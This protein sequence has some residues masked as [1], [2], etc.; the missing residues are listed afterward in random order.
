[1]AWYEHFRGNSPTGE[2]QL[3][4]GTALRL[5]NL[6]VGLVPVIFGW[7]AIFAVAE[8][9]HSDPKFWWYVGGVLALSLAAELVL[10]YIGQMLCYK[11]GYTVVVAFRR[12]IA[13]HL[14][15]LPLGFFAKNRMGEINAVLTDDVK[16]AEDY[17]THFFVELVLS[18]A[19][20]LV[21]LAVI[22]AIDYRLALSLVVLLPLGALILARFARV[23][24]RLVGEQLER[25]R[26][27]SAR[28][29]EYAFGIKTLRVFHRYDV[30]AEPLRKRLAAIRA[31]SMPIESAGGIGVLSFRLLAELGLALM[32]WLAAE[33]YSDSASP[34]AAWVLVLLL[35][36][37]YAFGILEASEFYASG[38]MVEKSGQNLAAVLEHPVFSTSTGGE[39]PAAITRSAD[40]LEVKGVSFSYT[41]GQNALTDV[42]LA[43]PEGTITAIVGPSGSGKSTLLSLLSGFYQPSE[44]RVLL[45]GKDYA[46]LGAD[47]I[48]EQLGVVFQDSFIFDGT[49]AA[50]VKLGRPEAS[51]DEVVAACEAALCAEFIAGLPEGYETML[52]EDGS[53]LSG[54]ERQRLAIARMMIKNPAIIIVDEMT[55]QL[56]PI[57]QFQVQ[58]ALSH[59]AR[60]K[61][62]IMVAHRLHTTKAADQIAVMD[63][64]R[65]VQL[66]RHDELLAVDD[67]YRRLWQSQT[68]AD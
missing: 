1:M 26:D 58:N 38:R 27:L 36:F 10:S 47:Q 28:L 15:N 20:C 37:R 61:T 48:Y 19:L 8:N 55:A 7:W 2:R 42:S 64:G 63:K 6:I 54:G 41:A 65:I 57:N 34:V 56:D 30:L 60:G 45:A 49:V 23:F 52:G 18:V 4:Q 66:G 5:L 53:R 68:G 11:G 22:I 9:R 29:V 21:I 67:L 43:I 35:A 39:P 3:V 31:A 12:R 32:F 33:L 46:A 40:L 44:G 16:K 51:H 50:N 24:A 13:D 14:R 17:F 59:L 25:Y 62:V